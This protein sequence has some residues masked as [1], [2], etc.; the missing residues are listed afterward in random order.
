MPLLPDIFCFFFCWFLQLTILF[1]FNFRTAA[2]KKHSLTHQQTNKHHTKLE[3]M[4][5]TTLY[6]IYFFITYVCHLQHVGIMLN[7]S[8]GNAPKSR[9]QHLKHLSGGVSVALNQTQQKA[10]VATEWVFRF[11]VEF[12]SLYLLLLFL[13][14]LCPAFNKC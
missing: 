6:G 9:L 3:A 14:L 10:H 8:W 5:K 13:L 11:L 4:Q 2:H 12:F 1:L 7:V